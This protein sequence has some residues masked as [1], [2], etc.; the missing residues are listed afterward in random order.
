MPPPTPF[1]SM[2]MFQ[3]PPE[4]LLFDA[5]LL[6]RHEER[7]QRELAVVHRL[8]EVEGGPRD[9]VVLLAVVLLR[10]DGRELLGLRV[11]GELDLAPLVDLD[12]PVAR[13]VL[14][15]VL[16]LV[17]VEVDD[18]V[19][20][21]VQVQR[22]GRPGLDLQRSAVGLA[23]ALRDALSPRRVAARRP[24]R[25]PAV[26][27]PRVVE[28]AALRVAVA[29]EGDLARL[30]LAR[31]RRTAGSR[32]REHPGDRGVPAAALEPRHVGGGAVGAEARQRRDLLRGRGGDRERLRGDGGRPLARVLAVRRLPVGLVEIAH[33]R[34]RRQERG[35]LH[36]PSG[37][38]ARAGSP[39]L[40]TPR[41]SRRRSDPGRGRRCPGRSR[42]RR[43]GCPARSRSGSRGRR[44][45]RC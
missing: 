17:V 39:P 26:A 33:L 15:V 5:R 12:L 40:L 18:E 10:L 43:S 34:D 11:P 24:G 30:Q 29:G 8:L 14:V 35:A 27:H 37:A 28:V 44:C 16:V 25:V 9:V 22:A 36:R 13:R 45:G 41:P 1:Q 4:V 42:S 38:P 7:P 21:H 23:A 32:A 3:G 2:L 19:G 6:P 20:A 31:E